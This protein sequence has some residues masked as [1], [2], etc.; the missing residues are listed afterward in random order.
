MQPSVS[1]G[2]VVGAVA[3][4][5][6]A[7]A[8]IPGLFLPAE[9]GG[10]PDASPAQLLL[11]QLTSGAL[12][13]QQ[14]QQ[15]SLPGPGLHRALSAAEFVPGDPSSSSSSSNAISASLAPVLSHADASPV[16]GGVTHAAGAFAAAAAA[17]HSARHASPAATESAAAAFATL[18]P[19]LTFDGPVSGPG[20]ASADALALL[21][22]A[23][24]LAPPPATPMVDSPAQQRLATAAD[25]TT[26]D[27]VLYAA[28]GY[29]APVDAPGIAACVAAPPGLAGDS[30][31][32]C[33]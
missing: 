14:H 19:P 7:P 28:C 29:D 2:E 25:E 21:H 5:L 31:W 3:F 22:A 26:C 30:V 12:L 33:R 23:L 27:A 10:A 8:A 9:G 1:D 16:A 18:T 24:A 4:P 32:T 20:G 15:I 13:Q 11:R 6:Q 17:L